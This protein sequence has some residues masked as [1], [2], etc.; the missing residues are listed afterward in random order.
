MRNS[1]TCIP[2]WILVLV[3]GSAV[4][5]AAAQFC[6]YPVEGRMRFEREGDV[7]CAF[8]VGLA[9]LPEEHEKGLMNCTGMREGFGLLFV[10]PGA[11][12]HTFWMKDTILPL[13][14]VFLTTEG[15]VSSIRYGEP[16]ST[17]GIPSGRPVGMVLE[18]HR[19]DADCLEVGDRAFLTRYP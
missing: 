5:G 8:E 19:S 14:I 3:L 12:R 7:V 9:D 16:Y 15:V 2:A 10:Y 4:C 1:R 13:A 18:I 11:A 6:G 17:R